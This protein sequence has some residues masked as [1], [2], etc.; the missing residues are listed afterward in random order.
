MKRKANNKDN[1]DGVFITIARVKNPQ[2]NNE[3][4]FAINFLEKTID[5]GVV[6]DLGA[7]FTGLARGQ[8]MKVEA[9][10]MEPVQEAYTGVQKP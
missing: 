10:D 8:I 1:I 2:N 5:I 4:G 9:P 7:Y 6:I 3:S